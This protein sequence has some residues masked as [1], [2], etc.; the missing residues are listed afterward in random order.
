M[1]AGSLL[2]ALRFTDDEALAL[3]FGLLLAGRAEGVALGRAA[4][5]ASNRLG[6]V[7][8]ER[9][10]GRLAALGHALS[11]PTAETP[12]VAVAESRLVLDVAEAAAAGRTLEL[13]YHGSSGTV[14]TRRVEPYGLVRLHRY[15]YLAGYCH[16]RRAAR[17]FRLDRVRCAHLLEER[18]TPPA[19]FDALGSV[20]RAVAGTPFPGAVTCR[21]FLGCSVAQAGRL[22]PMGATLLEPDEDGVLLRFH[23]PP[24]RLG[25]IALYLLGF[26]HEVRVLGPRALR[27]ALGGVSQRAAALATDGAW[28][29]LGNHVP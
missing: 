15:W 9:L 17:V 11:E 20:S 13:S 14:T 16:L 27:E 18:F 7:L 23:V 28:R 12:P 8:G 10:K 22:I 1:A 3:G 19:D 24:E 5:S 26:P 29:S 4:A 6:S 2:P 21:V 25:E